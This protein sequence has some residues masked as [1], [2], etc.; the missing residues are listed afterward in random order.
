MSVLPGQAT[1]IQQ[2]PIDRPKPYDRNARTHSADQVQ[3]IAASM[4]EFGFNNPIL[5]DEN[6]VIIAGH[7]RL[8]AAESLGLE[9]VPVIVLAHLSDAQRRAY[10]I[11]DNRLVLDAGWDEEI[12]AM[13]FT[14]LMAEGFELDVIGF[15]EDEIEDILADPDDLDEEEPDPVV[16]TVD[17]PIEPV[18]KEGDIWI[19]GEHRVMCGDS[20]MVHHVEALMNGET[21]QLMHADPP[22]GMGKESDGVANDNLYEEK[23]DAFQMDWWATFRTFLDDNASAYI[24]GNA[25]DLWRLWYR[26]G[27]CESEPLTLRN[28]IVWDKKSIAVMAS[29]DLTQYPEATERC[30]Y[31]QFGRHIFKVGQTKDEYWE[32][33]DPIRKWLSDQKEKAKLKAKDVKEICG[34]HM[35]GHWFGTSQWC[36]ISQDNYEKLQNATPDDCF[37]REY[38][39]L[40]AE[41]Q[42]LLQVFNGEIRDPKFKEFKAARP[43]FDNAHDVMRDVWEFSRVVGEERHGHATPKPVDMMQRVMNSSLRAGD[44]CVEP[45]GGSGSTLIGAELTGRR[46][47]TMEMQPRYVDVIVTRWQKQTGQK[48]VLESDGREWK[49]VAEE[50]VPPAD[51]VQHA[52]ENEE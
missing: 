51:R 28:E 50:R 10:I 30:L 45:F 23:L 49:E 36:M 37:G 8:E 16:A 35:Y 31:F 17:V 44:L 34:N 32:G 46:C 29:P 52:A 26:S 39:D 1:D 4:A 21:A 38:E 9:Q 33:W 19:C 42:Q 24:W 18:S 48:A 25:P 14:D 27:L 47:F 7:G 6:D 40:N 22:Y 2:W 12:L 11:A 20:T 41:Y 3:K 13:E 5:V 43:F 15:S